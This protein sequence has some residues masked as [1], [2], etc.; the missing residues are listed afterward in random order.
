MKTKFEI[1][2]YVKNKFFITIVAF[3]VWIVFFD[4]NNL[5]DRVKNMRELN[6]MYRDIEYYKVQIRTDSL[7]AREL[8]G[9]DENLEKFAREEYLMKK[10]NEDVFIIVE[11]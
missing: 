4:Q 9:N 11:E 6:K 2:T 1:P 5:I 3:V 8:L 10:D 7:K